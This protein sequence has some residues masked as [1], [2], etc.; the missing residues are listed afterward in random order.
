M[1]PG[2]CPAPPRGS[3]YELLGER[4]RLDDERLRPEV[5]RARPD[6][7]RLR[8]DDELLLEDERRWLE[9]ER[10]RLD[11]ARRLDEERVLPE[12]RRRLERRRE[13]FLRSDA[14]ISALTTAL[15]RTGIWR[16]RKLAMRSSS[17]RICLAILAVSL[18]PT[19][20]ASTSIAR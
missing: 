5:E 3:A 10:L 15:V 1:D 14:G 16:S 20:S 12:E 2:Y 19:S 17:R 11:E 13:P 8:P 4:R 6:D 18:S 7:E 9:E